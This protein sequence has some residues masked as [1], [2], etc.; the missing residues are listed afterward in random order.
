M[1]FNNNSFMNIDLS[2][3][4]LV[5]RGSNS[6]VYRYGTQLNAV[7]IKM[8]PSSCKK[9]TKHLANEYM[10]LSE[11]NHEN[12]IKVLRYKKELVVKGVSGS[13]ESSNSK[14]ILVLENASEGNLLE[15]FQ[16]AR[17]TIRQI[18]WVM[19]ELFEGVR[20]LHRNYIVHRD[21]KLENVLVNAGQYQ[22]H[23]KIADFGLA[24]R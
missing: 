2:R 10:M 18:R 23:I 11:I 24:K 5:S 16:K 4:K 20:Y 6:G 8:V 3:L 19:S 17:P 9:E 22:L 14:D 12:I 7:A 15:W 1:F 21:L 13:D